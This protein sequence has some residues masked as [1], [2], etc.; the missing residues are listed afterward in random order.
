MTGP[1]SLIESSTESPTTLN[2]DLG[3]RSYDIIIGEGL[4]DQAAAHIQPHLNSSRTYVI[5]D[6]NLATA[7]LPTLEASL[8]AAGIDFAT[9]ILPAGEQTKSFAYVDELTSWLLDQGVDRKTTLIA[10]GG[11]VIGDLT[12]FVAA[13]TLRG[14]PFIQVPTTLL[15]Q[16][17]SSVGGKTAIDT[18]QGK[19]LIGAFHQPALV[20]IDTDVLD[21][22]PRRQVLAGYAEVVKYGLINAPDFFDWCE[23]NA[24]ALLNGDS[25]A[26]RHAVET[27]CR[28][29]AEIVAED[30]LESGKR[31]L[32][33]LG[34]TFGHALEAEAGY[35]DALVHGEAV[36]FGCLCALELSRR[37]DL[38]PGQDVER[39]RA[40]FA[41]VGLPTK[42]RDLNNG[43]WAASL[44]AKTIIGHM[45][46]D[47]KVESGQ[48]TFILARGIGQSFTTRDVPLDILTDL[49]SELLQT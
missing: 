27:S 17:D 26:R 34:H 15:A 13:I 7:W 22:L 45:A 23:T 10:L 44:S 38:C 5:T 19:N 43:S 1:E 8:T 41:R 16:V 21:T 18:P 28:I 42:F 35:S 48:L 2:V 24:A 33:N 32:L 30:E 46:K 4:I 14:I 31:A 49:L 36:A 12:G 20:L 3:A 39:V 11:G 25:R 6:E 9:K 47:K 40:H 37:L 29:K